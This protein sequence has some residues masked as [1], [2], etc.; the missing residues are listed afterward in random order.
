MKF[1]EGNVFTPVSD[2]VH[3]GACMVEGACMVK[4]CTYQ[5]VVCVAK[6]ACMTKTDMHSEWEVCMVKGSM[7]SKGGGMCGKGWHAWQRGHA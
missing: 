1:W 6:D 3:R 2:S 5:K 4:G 7:H